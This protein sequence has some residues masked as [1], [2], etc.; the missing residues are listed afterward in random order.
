MQS[1]FG[2]DNES[3][4]TLHLTLFENSSG[5]QVP[6][7][8]KISK[9]GLSEDVSIEF[10]HGVVMSIGGKSVQ[11]VSVDF[12]AVSQSMSEKMGRKIILTF[13]KVKK[14]YRPKINMSGIQ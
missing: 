8:V 11:G 12:L 7:R 6:M 3:I 10:K 5:P 14:S 2:D 1:H 13:R 4:H 9:K